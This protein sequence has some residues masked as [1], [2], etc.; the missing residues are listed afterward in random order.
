M[1]IE[2]IDFLYRNSTKESMILL[3]DSTKRDLKTSPNIADFQIV[4]EEPFTYVYGIEILDTTIPRTM[5]MVEE[6]VNNKL[7]YCTDLESGGENNIQLKSQDFS[8]TDILFEAF[9][10]LF[11]KTDEL[12][13]VDNFEEYYDQNVDIQDYY[14]RSKSD[15]P[16]MT[17]R[18]NKQFYFNITK[19]NIYKTLGFSMIPTNTDHLKYNTLSNA[20]STVTQVCKTSG[21]EKKMNLL[22]D[23]RVTKINENKYVYIH[24]SNVPESYISKIEFEEWVG[25]LN[26]K[27]NNDKLL[28]SFT[29]VANDIQNVFSDI[30]G[31]ILLRGG[32]YIF[33][34]D[35]AVAIYDDNAVTNKFMVTIVDFVNVDGIINDVIYLSVPNVDTIDHNGT[36]IQPIKGDVVFNLDFNESRNGE[37][38]NIVESKFHVFSTNQMNR[39]DYVT[40]KNI[41]LD[42]GELHL[43]EDDENPYFVLRIY[44]DDDSLFMDI[45][46]EFTQNP[47]N[48][49]TLT[50]NVN[51][52]DDDTMLKMN[53][54]K[55]YFNLCTFSSETSHYTFEFL[56]NHDRISSFVKSRRIEMEINWLFIGDNQITAPGMINLAAENYVLLR[57]DE[58]ENHLRG[59]YNT[60]KY[61]P[62]LGVLNIGVQGYAESKNDF[63]S[64]KYKEFHPIGRLTKM[65]F[66]FERKSDRKL[67]DFKHIDLHFLLSI[68]FFRPSAKASFERSILN[69]EYDSNFI[70]YIN[71]TNEY[72]EPSS[73]EEDDLSDSEDYARSFNERENYLM[74]SM[75]DDVD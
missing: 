62:G 42:L 44:K 29:R 58:I 60:E 37:N 63:F 25:T 61:T 10:F 70:S 41:T 74:R 65:S 38:F 4:F 13:E 21:L 11:N 45:F 6:N 66:R 28:R 31:L 26:I 36:S 71:N 51:P 2:D 46:L 30:I 59:S 3:V 24:T 52:G 67:Y 43:L 57:C 12:W 16:I 18:L 48:I 39:Y 68:K 23:T 1:P 40:V 33:E 47:D 14:V 35:N 72:E 8:T 17:F 19:S 54:L 15:N 56:T 32:T 55:R 49:C 20:L 64:V 5:F 7:V 34:F 53:L 27:N 75:G 69:P 9:S 22:T 73:D 50:Y